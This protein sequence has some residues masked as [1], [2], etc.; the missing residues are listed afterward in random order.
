MGSI[1]VHAVINDLS[2]GGAETLLVDFATTVAEVD[3]EMSVSFLRAGDSQASAD[4][5]R[6]LGVE[7]VLVP[8]RRLANLADHRAVRA[9]LAAVGPDVVHT[10]LGTADLVGGLA[11]R[12]LGL[13]HVSTLH[14]FDW[15][16]RDW[17]TG[18]RKRAG[19][20]LVGTARRRLPRRLIAPSQALARGYLERTGDASGH[21]VTMHSGSARTARPGAGRA[22]REELGLAPGAFVV[23]MVSWLHPLKGHDVAI[24]AAARLADRIPGMRLLIVGDGPEEERL[25]GHAERLA[26]AT[27]FAGYRPDVMEVLDGADLLLHPSRM[28]NFPITL[29]EAMAARVP[30]LATRVGGVPEI[31]DD[32][33]TGALLEPPASVEGVADAIAALHDDEP[34]RTRLAENARRRFD[35]SFTASAWAHRLRGF[36]ETEL[37]L[38]ERR[39]DP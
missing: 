14:G 12:S 2:F 21:V 30:I 7:P 3:I 22:V 25:R 26:P 18:A 29:L 38:G 8:F 9:H 31:V 23:V 1:H 24:E 27:V 20:A 5:L 37:G 28:E 17:G 36:Y 13:P 19:R 34:L 16:S 15:E 32:G 4:R 6:A 35:E 39:L 11:A 33:V 10:H